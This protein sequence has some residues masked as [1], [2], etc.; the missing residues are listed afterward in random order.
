MPAQ[1]D[2]A[3]EIRRLRDEL[4]TLRAHSVIDPLTGLFDPHGFR[5]RLQSELG[6][7]ERDG[8]GLSLIALRLKS[9]RKIN[10]TQGHGSGDRLLAALAVAMN[11]SIRASDFCG[12]LSG[13]EF[14]V[15]LPGA[16]AAEAE[17]VLERIKEACSQA[18][19]PEWP[20]PSVS[21]GIATH[22]GE[23]WDE[24]GRRRVGSRRRGPEMRSASMSGQQRAKLVATEAARLY[25]DTTA[26]VESARALAM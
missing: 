15:A 8:S 19:G 1:A 7:A 10:E 13:D 24:F 11:K 4:E 16:D 25:A 23:A 6:R 14:M 5:E 20:I 3:E 26:M 9:L 18:V 12:R 22:L 17:R 2:L 21:A